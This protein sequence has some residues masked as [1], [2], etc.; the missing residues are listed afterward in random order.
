MFAKSVTS[1]YNN[2]KIKTVSHDACI[3]RGE[4]QEAYAQIYY[5]D[6]KRRLMSHYDD[7]PI[8]MCTSL[9]DLPLW[10]L[11]EVQALECSVDGSSWIWKKLLNF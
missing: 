9:L 4:L 10:Y 11:E 3:I 1:A 8:P 6:W 2:T 7:V 5:A